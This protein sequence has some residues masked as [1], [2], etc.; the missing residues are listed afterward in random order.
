MYIILLLCTRPDGLC[1]KQTHKQTCIVSNTMPRRIKGRFSDPFGS[2][3]IRFVSLLPLNTHTVSGTA[4]GS[5]PPEPSSSP[6]THLT[7]PS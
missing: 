2:F 5:R 4:R 6:E 1:P 7:P 3:V